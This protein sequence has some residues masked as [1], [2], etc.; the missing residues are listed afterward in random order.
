MRQNYYHFKILWLDNEKF[1][2]LIVGGYNT[3]F[4]YFAYSLFFLLLGTKEGYVSVLA[5]SYLLSI[6][7]AFFC[8][9]FLVFKS[10]KKLTNVFLRYLVSCVL[11]FFVNY[12]FLHLFISHLKVY[13]LV[14]QCICVVFLIFLSYFLNKKFT[15]Q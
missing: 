11:L 9:K 10:K 1:R 15:F 5:Q 12:F 6:I 14:A 7:S 3:V 4:G 2:Y 8:M 13:S